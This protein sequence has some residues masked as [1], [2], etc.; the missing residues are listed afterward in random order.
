MIKA[1]RLTDNNT[2]FGAKSE[3]KKHGEDEPHILPNTLR[4]RVAQKMDKT[5]SAFTE[6]PMKGF[7]GDVNSDFYEFLSMGIIPYLAG[8]AMFMLMFNMIGKLDPKSKVLAGMNGK[9]MALGVVL[10]G[11]SFSPGRQFF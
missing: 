3:A 8:S 9:K 10:Y 2:S 6:Y 11:S 5:M 4:T 1:V 7:R